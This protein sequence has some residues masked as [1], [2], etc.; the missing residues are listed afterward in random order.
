MSDEPR[1]ARDAATVILA[2]DAG[3]DFEVFMLRRNAR[4]S[5]MASAYVYPGG[6]LDEGD[7][8]PEAA[9]HVRGL[10][11]EAARARLDEPI[12]PARA[13]GLF[14]A[15]VRETFEEAGVLLARAPGASRWVDLTRDSAREERFA[16]YREALRT[17][18]LS[19][20]EVLARDDLAPGLAGTL[21]LSAVGLDGPRAP[22]L[23][24]VMRQE[25]GP[26]AAGL[27]GLTLVTGGPPTGGGMHG[28]LHPAE[29]ST[30]LA[31]AAPGAAAGAVDPRPC[32]ILDV[33]PT[34]LALLGLPAAGMDGAPLPLAADGAEGETETLEAARG[35]F[36]QRLTRRRGVDGRL[37]LER[38]GRA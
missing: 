28:G 10:D 19:L 34:V 14:L 37:A 26:D 3:E 16:A 20:S 23:A 38:G 33:A 30:L 18:E 35:A 15:G 9:R 11:P 29:L 12:S 17:C 1:P 13:L 22:E 24:Y 31:V 2:R 21:P 36:R 32:G 4:A 8:T 6:A 7:C 25:D 27:P 5:F